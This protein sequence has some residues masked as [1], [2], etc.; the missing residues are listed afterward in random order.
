MVLLSVSNVTVEYG[1]DVVLENISF[2]V[3]EGDRV[4]IIGV[5]GAGKSTLAKIIAGT[6]SHF[7]GNVFMASEK[8]VAMLEQN[9]MLDSDDTVLSEMLGA[10]PEVI[11]A[12]E[13]L[14]R[15]SARL[16]THEATE[17]EIEEYSALTEKF[18]EM[19]GYEYRSKIKAT[20]ARFGFFEEDLEK[21]VNILSGGERTRLALVKLLLREPDL[22]ILDEPT[23]HLDIDTI[24]WLEEHL[25]SYKKT[26]I[27]IS[28]DRY[29]LDR[30]TTKTLEIEHT[31]A[32]LYS[33]NY[34]AYAVQKA[35]ARKALA[36]K[37][38]L[39]QKEIGRIEAMIDQ[40]RR[41][42]QEHNFVTIR[43]K[44]KQIEHMEKV[45]APTSDPKN[46]RMHFSEA[47][48]SGN[49]VL[50]VEKLS[51]S[52][53]ERKVLDSI[54]FEVKKRDRLMIIGPN[55]CG[56][57]TLA[58]ILGELDNEYSGNV[59]FGYNI[60]KGYYDQEQQTLDDSA[61]VLEEVCRAHDKL[62]MTEV[63]T[64]LA[65]FLFF[66]EDMDK[67]IAVL[68]GGERARLMLCK[69]I[70]SKINL[71]ILDEPTNHLDIGSREALEDALED[72]SGT[73]IA[74]SHD[75]YFI[76]KLSTRILDM[77]R[78][79]PRDYLGGY[80][81]YL[82]RCA[83]SAQETVA[84]EP[85]RDSDS[86]QK[87]MESKKLSSDIRR[88]ESRIKRAEDEIKAL[89]AEHSALEA[90]SVGDACTDYQRLGEI[91]TRISEIDAR[92]DWLYEEM[93]DAEATLEALGGKA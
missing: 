37:Y 80:D 53:G 7:S 16:E 66:A 57:S 61:T 9:A 31:R 89:E 46:I 82:E 55:G 39:Q 75:R 1:T 41:W 2:S 15:L 32:T 29:F 19:G 43:S 79:P 73:I 3:G 93:E 18:K 38:E 65:S 52:F 86:K 22:L 54:S 10:F 26:L 63:R 90:E 92:L 62:T 74:V 28:H 45:D 40:Q 47:G 83:V 25:R 78:N 50:F 24:S 67:K 64:A 35:E 59:R 49:D 17:K 20:L 51:K 87:Y 14:S 48:E 84:A 56:K 91:Y 33:G 81:E 30:A 13:R 6:F 69:M 68:S 11:S 34:S 44:Q 12:E 21:T 70:L 60:K 42:G 71:L 88:C 27:L 72:F 77:S 5:N 85:R 23:N 36:K 58:R 76:K 8:T 4:G